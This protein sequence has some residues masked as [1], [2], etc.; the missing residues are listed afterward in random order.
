MLS[1]IWTD[2]KTAWNWFEAQVAKIMPGLKT[3][4]VSGLGAIGSL[5]AVLQEYITG[6]PL[7]EFMTGTQVAVATTVLFTL[8]FWFHNMSDRT[9]TPTIT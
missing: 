4:I 3:Y 2:I 6:L 7:N 5:A 9:N 8:A 1:N